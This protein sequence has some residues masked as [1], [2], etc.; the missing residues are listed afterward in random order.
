MSAK[1]LRC[2]KLNS[3]LGEKSLPILLD[4]FFRQERLCLFTATS[5]IILTWIVLIYINKIT[6]TQDQGER[7]EIAFQ[8]HPVSHQ[9]QKI[10]ALYFL[11]LSFSHPFPHRITWGDVLNNYKH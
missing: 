3:K 5:L 4:T 1:V 11:T 9:H 7:N 2:F 6:K 10:S 8:G